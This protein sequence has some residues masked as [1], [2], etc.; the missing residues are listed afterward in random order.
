MQKGLD[1]GPRSVHNGNHCNT[2]QRAPNMTANTADLKILQNRARNIARQ[3]PQ[4]AALC[5]LQIARRRIAD[6][7]LFVTRNPEHA[8]ACAWEARHHL[9]QCA[10]D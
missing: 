9:N 6:V 3:N 10:L 2:T 7:K 8:T 5:H 4:G 1:T